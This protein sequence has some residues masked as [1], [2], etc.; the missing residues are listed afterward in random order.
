MPDGLM[1][2]KPELS[3][4]QNDGE[5]TFRTLVRL[6]QS[7]GFFADPSRIL[8]QLKFLD[9]LVAFVLPLPAIGGWVRAFLDLSPGE[10]MRRIAR[11]S[12]IFRLMNIR[13]LRRHKPP[14]LAMEIHIRLSHGYAGNRTQLRIDLL[15]QIH[16]LVYRKHE[17]SDLRPRGA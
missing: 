7:Y 13:T 4:I 1:D 16:I 11:A 6:V 9:Q 15:Q 10:R 12:G 17:R 5:H 14:L 8:H 2:L 3:A